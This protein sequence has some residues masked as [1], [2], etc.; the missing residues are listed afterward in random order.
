LTV[1]VPRHP[2]RFDTVAAILEKRGISF[3]RRSNAEAVGAVA[4]LLGDSMGEMATYYAAC[5]VAFIGGS[6]L[7]YGGQNLIEACAMGKPVVVGT[8]TY[9]FE[10]TVAQAL[11]LGAARRVQN[12]DE[13]LSTLLALL[14]N[15]EQRSSMGKAGKAFAEANRG[16]TQ[17]TL[18][19]IEKHL[20]KL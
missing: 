17:C 6:L 1:I 8:Y 10:Q 9:N 7:P 13:L 2:Q 12:T 4:M 16:A 14:T 11:K 3:A 18:A 19:V 5:D 20:P 15:A